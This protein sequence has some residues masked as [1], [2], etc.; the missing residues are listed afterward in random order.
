[1]RLIRNTLAGQKAFT[2]N[3]AAF[4]CLPY[5]GM[6]DWRVDEL[7]NPKDDHCMKGDRDNAEG[8]AHNNDGVARR[9]D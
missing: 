5:T 6:D 4:P 1:M 2:N 7:S 8:A 9:K 3:L